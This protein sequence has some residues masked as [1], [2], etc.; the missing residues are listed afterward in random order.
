ML[1]RNVT[2]AAGRSQLPAH[3]FPRR[4][5]LTAGRNLGP[6]ISGAGPV[7][8]LGQVLPAAVAKGAAGSECLSS[9]LCWSW[10]GGLHGGQLL[11]SAAFSSLGG[12]LF[13]HLLLYPLRRG[14]AFFL[15]CVFP[16]AAQPGGGGCSAVGAAR[17]APP[18]Q[19]CCCCRVFVQRQQKHCFKMSDRPS[20]CFSS[21]NTMLCQT[22]FC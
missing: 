5:L 6:G 22:F 10:A 9:V 12:G 2:A 13:P 3:L 17:E 21:L 15:F 1:G 19:G 20:P 11:P 4:M 14:S 7:C 18:A 8:H 16:F